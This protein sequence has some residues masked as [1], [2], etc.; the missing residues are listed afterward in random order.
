MKNASRYDRQIKLPEIGTVGQQKLQQASVLLVGVGGLG[1]PS[2]QYLAAAG[3]GHIGL[4]DHDVVDVTNLHRQVLYSERHIGRPKVEAAE[5]ALTELNSEISIST[6]QVH[7]DE[8]NALD[9]LR[10]YDII[11]DGTD[12]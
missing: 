3:V 5:E 8:N 7:L 9:I 2:A 4:L 1:C 12:P 6:H 10:D 11:L